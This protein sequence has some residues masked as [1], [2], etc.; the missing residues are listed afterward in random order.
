[1]QTE[2]CDVAIIGAGP[3]GAIA[4]SILADKGWHVKVFE[5]QHF[6]RFSIG[7]SLLPHCAEFIAEAG[8]M[9][10]IEAAGFQYKDGAAFT[11]D[12]EYEDIYFPDKS[13]PGPGTIFQVQRD[14]FDKVLI[15]G[16]AAKGVEVSFGETVVSFSSESELADH[17]ELIVKDEA[18][19][20]RA[21][22]SRFVIDGSGFGRV[23]PRLLDL[24][25]P[26]DQTKRRS[27]FKHVTDNIDHPDFDRN[28][29]L[30]T[31]HPDDP[32][33]WL[34]LIPLSNGLSS[35]GVVGKDEVIKQAGECPESRLDHYVRTSGL[36]GDVM[37]NAVE[38]RPANEIVGFSANVKNLYGDKYVLLGNA[39]EF[40]D[41]VFSSGVTIATKSAS[42]AAKLI[43]EQLK[44]HSVD[45]ENDFAVELKRGVEA[46]RACV[47]AWYDG[48]LQRL[49]FMD[50]RSEDMTRYFTA[51]LAGYA[52]DESN[53]IVKDPKR[54]FRLMDALTKEDA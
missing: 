40:L 27:C 32:Q 52:W 14:R 34:W 4:A 41:P 43:D 17:A 50:N 22:R 8:L 12:G 7:E 2:T 21:I 13:T 42:L 10:A 24:E 31:V 20:E 49:I 29:I 44:G 1:M 18:G 9:D 5:R 19:E 6:P 54:F 53:P 48:L 36:M 46:F 47:N 33:V 3:S 11:M 16:T 35:I 23:L 15:D 28:K 30:I 37:A 38:A 39:A 26:S 45:W 51:I 25:T